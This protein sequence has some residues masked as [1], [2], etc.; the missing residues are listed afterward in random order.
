MGFMEPG[1]LCPSDLI[2][3][4]YSPGGD[5]FIFQV[6]D[7]GDVL[8]REFMKE[9]ALRQTDEE[10]LERMAEAGRIVKTMAEIKFDAIMEAYEAHGH[11]AK[12]ACK[13]LRISK[14]TFYREL[15]RHNYTIEKKATRR[16][17][18]DGGET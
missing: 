4:K 11:N 18:P 9:R 10:E 15:R 13:E 8:M 14:A 2:K 6:L 7:G 17:E 5:S 3:W 12:A 16:E 1:V